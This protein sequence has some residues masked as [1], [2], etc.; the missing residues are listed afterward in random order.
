MKSTKTKTFCPPVHLVY[1]DTLLMIGGG[2]GLFNNRRVTRCLNTFFRIVFYLATLS[3]AM[4]VY[5]MFTIPNKIVYLVIII[6]FY[7][8]A[9]CCQNTIRRATP[10]LRQITEA[11][12]FLLS[13]EALEDIR[14]KDKFFGILTAVCQ[15][16]TAWILSFVGVYHTEDT[17]F[18]GNYVILFGPI[19]FHI[20]VMLIFGTCIFS[21]QYFALLSCVF[22]K[23]A[24]Q[25]KS[26]VRDVILL[27]KTDHLSSGDVK[28]VRK[29]LRIYWELKLEAVSSL[30]SLPF[31]W[32][33]FVFISMTGLCIRSFNTV[34][35]ISNLGFVSE[36]IV[37][38]SPEDIAMIIPNLF[39]IGLFTLCFV[40]VIHLADAMDSKTSNLISTAFK[41]TDPRSV[42]TKDAEV[43]KE[44]SLLQQDLSNKPDCDWM[45]GPYPLKKEI[46]LGFTNS[47]VTF[48]VMIITTRIQIISTSNSSSFVNATLSKN[49][50]MSP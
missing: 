5:F 2:I 4:F 29:Y 19:M 50:T 22:G 31:A 38:Y 25:F 32:F 17:R 20:Y 26:R 28:K 9:F 13:S 15:E 30:R 1:T 24:E 10:K 3:I 8:V 6:I 40:P 7:A 46:L 23:L 42:E 48:T 12:N 35:I 43:I 45:A 39:L 21:M 11:F 16:L 14:A 33:T 34:L 41:L 47:V 37:N 44:L 49:L 18:L 27:A 36:A